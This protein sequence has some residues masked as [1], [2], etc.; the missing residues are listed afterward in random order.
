MHLLKSYNLFLETSPPKYSI[1]DFLLSLISLGHFIYACFRQTR[2]STDVNYNAWRCYNAFGYRLYNYVLPSVISVLVQCMIQGYNS[3]KAETK[4]DESALRRFAKIFL[5]G[6]TIL[7]NVGICLVFIP[8][9]LI[10]AFPMLVGFCWLLIPLPLLLSL[11]YAIFTT[12]L[13]TVVSGCKFE[14]CG[15]LFGAHFLVGLQV[16]GCLAL[17]MAY[18]Y[19]QY[20]YFGGG[21]LTVLGYEFRSR[22]TVA[23]GNSLSN[24]T[25]L[26]IHSILAFF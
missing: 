8:Y 19:S 20:T 26:Q 6:G 9:F 14:H 21:Y 5:L 16:F 15:R 11:A 13:V 23:W 2:C 25:E 10:N 4:D 17:S 24:N 22:D 7:M 12:I 3:Y 1:L 18:N